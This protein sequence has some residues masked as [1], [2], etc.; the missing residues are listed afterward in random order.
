MIN[1]YVYTDEG[2]KD[3]AIQ[4]DNGA[5]LDGLCTIIGSNYKFAGYLDVLLCSCDIKFTC[6]VVSRDKIKLKNG[7]QAVI[8]KDHPYM[9]EV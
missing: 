1:L 7:K 6:D 9:V 5:I 3:F 4:C 2:I 8:N